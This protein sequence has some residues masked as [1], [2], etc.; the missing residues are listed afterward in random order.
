MQ[1]PLGTVEDFRLAFH[2][3]VP[4]NPDFEDMKKVVCI[5]LKRPEIPNR[6]SSDEVY[7]YVIYNYLGCITSSYNFKLLL[8]L[9]ALLLPLQIYNKKKD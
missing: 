3:C 9:S 2:D 8:N 6:W 4:S 7:S 5:E 1:L